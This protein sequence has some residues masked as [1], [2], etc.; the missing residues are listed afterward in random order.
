V[1]ARSLVSSW[2]IIIVCEWNKEAKPDKLTGACHLCNRHL[3]IPVAGS[4][5]I[6]FGP[7]NNWPWDC[8]RFPGRPESEKLFMKAGDEMPIWGVD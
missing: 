4:F 5:R 3:K 7:L 2:V 8:I 6:A 1:G